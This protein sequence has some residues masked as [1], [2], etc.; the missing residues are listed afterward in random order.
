VKE[1]SAAVQHVSAAARTISSATAAAFETDKN[2]TDPKRGKSS[3][4]AK[5][6]TLLT[7]E[8]RNQGMS[9]K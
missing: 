4:N 1:A 3:E 5:T 7:S 6:P 2:E 8:V 9:K